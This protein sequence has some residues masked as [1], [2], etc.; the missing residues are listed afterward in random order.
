MFNIKQDRPY[1]YDVTLSRVRAI[2]VAV[3]K[4]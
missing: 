3:E 1:R 4:Q 2:I